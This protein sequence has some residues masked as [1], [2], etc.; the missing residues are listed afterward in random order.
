MS[1]PLKGA[2]PGTPVTFTTP[3]SMTGIQG[4]YDFSAS[5]VA[6]GVA[7]TSLTDGSGN[8]RTITGAATAQPLSKT[9]A[10]GINNL[11]VALF[12]G[13]NDVMTTASFSVSQPFTIYAVVTG[14][15]AGPLRYFANLTTEVVR[16]GYDATTGANAF[17]GVSLTGTGTAAANPKVVTTVFN[18]ASS[19]IRVDRSQVTS[20]DAGSSNIA[21]GISVGGTGTAQFWN[22]KIGELF[23]TNV[24][25]VDTGAE[26]Y[27]KNKWGT[28]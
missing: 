21:N 3:A 5:G 13:V 19:I 22:G 28:P 23:W 24:A 8:G 14:G 10:N 27:L 16:V 17:A 12:D 1:L 6:D 18:G 20:G 7:I 15:G 4:W 25:S 11:A 2:G 9:G 26:T